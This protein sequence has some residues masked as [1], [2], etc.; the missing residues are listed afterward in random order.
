MVA[1]EFATAYSNRGTCYGALGQYERAIADCDRAIALAPD[2]ATAYS[3]RGNNYGALGQHEQAI[4]DH[5]RAITL[6]PDFA[7]VYFNKGLLLANTGRLQ[8]ALPLFEKADMLGHPQAVSLIQQ[9]RQALGLPPMQMQVASNDPQAA[10]DAFQRVGSLNA[11][12]QLLTQFPILVQMIPTIE[13]VIQQQVPAEGRPPLDQRLAWL[14]QIAGQAQK[15]VAESEEEQT[16]RQL[17][18]IYQ[19]RGELGLRQL[20]QQEGLSASTIANIIDLVKQASGE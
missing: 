19:E 2:N 6:A 16:I 15:S 20:L 3:N 7:P 1:P 14:R 4:T 12:R 5:D 9:V 10:F 13:Q 17:V 8:E 18:S 11:M